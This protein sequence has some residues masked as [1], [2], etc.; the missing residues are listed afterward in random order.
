MSKVADF[1][2]EKTSKPPAQPALLVLEDGTVFSGTA[3][4]ASGEA[5]GEICFN[6]SLEGY[7]EIITDPSYAGQIVVLT[8]PQVGNY[9]VHLDDVQAE[10][11]ALR[12]L[13]VRD[14]CPTPSSWRSQEDLGSFLRREGVVAIEGIDTRALVRHIRDH[15]AQKAVIS[16]E[17]SNVDD[18]VAKVRESPSLVGVNLAATVSRE[19]AGSYTVADL[20]VS[21]GFAAIPA[22]ETRFRVVAYDCGAKRSILENL[23]RSGCDVTVVPWNTAAEEVLALNPDGVFMSNGPGDPDAVAETYQQVEKLLGKVPV[24]GICLGHQMMA[25][26]A[27]ADIEKLKFGHHGGNHPVQNLLTGRVEVTAQNHGFCPRFQSL[28]ALMPELSGGFNAHE[29]DLRCWAAR[30]VAPVVANERFGRIQLTHVNLDDGTAEGFAF[31]DIPAFSVQYHPE[32]SPGPTDAHYLFT[33][34]A[35]LMTGAEDYLDID[36]AADRLAGWKFGETDE[37]KKEVA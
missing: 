7:L 23:V 25:K 17:S 1:L 37:T 24:F 6:T 8:Y 16:T 19:E 15:G 21:H 12:G 9:G 11:P 30:G 3:C 2:L 27:G 29:E 34:F 31:L 26:A 13:I 5:F 20:P 33:A 32:A 14:L 18:L 35:R 36:I 22:P 10:H 28:G 4:G